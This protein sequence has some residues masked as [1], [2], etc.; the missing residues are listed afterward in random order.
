MSTITLTSQTTPTVPSTNKGK[1]FYS[2]TLDSLAFEDASGNVARLAGLSTTDYR[3]LTI[4][5]IFSG[6]TSYTPTTGVRA[7]FIECIGGGGAGGGVATAITNAGAAGGGGGGAYSCTWNITNVSGTHTVAV[8][9][10][11]TAGAAGANPGGVGG[12]TDFKDTAGTSI[13][14]AKGGLGGLADTVAAIHVGGLSVAGGAAASG[15]GDLKIDG[16]VSGTGLALAAAQAVSG[17][18]GASHFGSGAAS[19]KTQGAGVAAGVYG[20]GGSGGCILSGG[21]SVAGGA[22]GAGL[23]RV[24]EF[25]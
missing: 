22:G 12:D 6:T 8:G 17:S 18:G 4:T 16:G 14:T 7:L 2:S 15:V 5:E 3:L 24:W 10:G 13:C 23:I 1:I 19:R 25:A 21:A 20:G 9:A 11:G